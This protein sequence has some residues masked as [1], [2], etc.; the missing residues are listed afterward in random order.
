MKRRLLSSIIALTMV[1]SVGCSSA[2]AMTPNLST[3]PQEY[4]TAK[5]VSNKLIDYTG[6]IGYGYID[7]TEDQMKEKVA[8]DLKKDVKDLK[9]VDFNKNTE[10]FDMVPGVAVAKSGGKTVKVQKSDLMKYDLVRIGG[11]YF[12]NFKVEEFEKVEYLTATI[13]STTGCKGFSGVY[14]SSRPSFYQLDKTGYANMINYIRVN[15]DNRIP[16][17]SEVSMVMGTEYKAVIPNKNAVIR[18]VVDFRHS[19]SNPGEH[20]ACIQ[21]ID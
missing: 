2:S 15:T 9:Y 18:D 16:I 1:M 20:V 19:K 12:Y 11:S 17:A 3:K 7:W 8:K 14:E 13:L 10:R 6:M 5:P 21:I 4:Q